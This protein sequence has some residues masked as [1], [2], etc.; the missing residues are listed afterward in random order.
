[1]KL[2]VVQWALERAVWVQALAWDI[3]FCSW[4][5]RFTHTVPLYLHP[6]RCNEWAV[7]SISFKVDIPTGKVGG[8]LLFERQ[9]RKLPRGVW[10]HA[11]PKKILKSRFSEMLFSPFSRQCLGLKNNQN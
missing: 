5:R 3:V 1:M 6:W 11:P 9:R 8:S 10:G 7:L 2:H 4:A